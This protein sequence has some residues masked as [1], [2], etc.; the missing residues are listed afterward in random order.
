LFSGYGD[1]LLD[2]N[3]R[4]SVFSIGFSLAEW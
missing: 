3:R 2:F 1:T 4:R